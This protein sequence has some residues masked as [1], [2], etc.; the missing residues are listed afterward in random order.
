[1]NLKGNGPFFGE[2]NCR[3]CTK[4]WMSAFCW[5]E[6]DEKTKIPQKCKKC[7]I[8]AFP[9]KMVWPFVHSPSYILV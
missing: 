5:L 3:K 8:N 1:M 9:M 4:H 7:E 2:F 6:D